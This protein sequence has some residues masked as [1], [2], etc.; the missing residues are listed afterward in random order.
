MVSKTRIA[1]LGGGMASLAAAFELTNKPELRDQYDV[2][3][4][5]I[6]WRLGGK[7]AS[8]RNL[9]MMDRIEE[10]GL[11]VWFGFYDNAFRLIR[12]CYEELGRAPS[13]PLATWKDAFK[14]HNFEVL[15]E[16]YKDRWVM[17]PLNFPPNDDVP[18]NRGVLPS[19]WAMCEMAFGWLWELFHDLIGSHG[20]LFQQTHTPHSPK[21]VWWERLT[22]ELD[23]AIPHGIDHADYFALAMALIK[24]NKANPGA[25]HPGHHS[26]LC[27]LINTFKAWVWD[28]LEAHIDDD[29]VRFFW[30]MYDLATAV[31]CGMISDDLFTHSFDTIDSVEFCEWLRKHGANDTPAIID[32]PPVRAIYD[33]AFCYENGDITKPNMGAGA[34]LR[35]FLR[36]S[37]T[38]KGALLYKMQ[39]GMGDTVFTPLYEVLQ[40]RGVKFE[41]FHCVTNLGLDAVS[42]NIESITV[43]PQVT[44]TVGEYDPL[45]L[46]KELGCWPSEPL[47]DQID[48]AQVQV[49]KQQKI[50]LERTCGPFPEIP[51]VTLQRGT[52]FDAVVLGISLAAL[53]AISGELMHA[54]PKFD[55]MTKN[56]KTVITQAFQVWMNKDL[57]ELGWTMESPIFGTY[58]EPLDTYADMSHLIDRENWPVQYNLQNI[59]YFC[60]V[61]QGEAGDTQ[62]KV[63]ERAKK[64]ALDY[65]TGAAAYVWPKV[66]GAGTFDWDALVDP[67]E[68]SGIERFDSQYWRAN[69][70]PTEQYVVSFVDTTKYRLKSDQSG[71]DNLY[72]V[73][74]WTLN[75]FNAG[76]IEAATM[77]AMQASRAICGFPKVITGETDQWL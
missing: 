44:L 43:Q 46:I 16:Y 1:V 62:E 45:V 70:V 6:G 8:G 37:L 11:H 56:V 51:A 25:A 4:Y 55:A 41:F 17:W 21:P 38:Y 67:G 27:W 60:G 47:Y 10:H 26:I 75:G 73:G 57:A 18:G 66:G 58:V 61:L 31:A 71:F 32:R 48:P 14:P 7:G 68:C 39:A 35:S 22:N 12:E 52:D 36:I 69:F 40:R 53:P 2:T 77:S 30:V 29:K 72:L 13:A 28:A 34:A 59:A 23:A 20:H 3:V 15:N 76:C 64:A 50:D 5:Q 42:K 63:D 74:D 33:T 24:R 65:L 54:N 19:F 9:Q 49:L